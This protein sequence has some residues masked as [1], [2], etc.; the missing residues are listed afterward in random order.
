[1]M[2]F[3]CVIFSGELLKPTV[4][5]PVGL[6]SLYLA[7]VIVCWCV[8]IGLALV[9]LSWGSILVVFAASVTSLVLFRK[10][11]LVSSF[12]GTIWPQLACLL[13]A[14]SLPHSSASLFI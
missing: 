8:F 4:N 7:P 9:V 13:P 1:M 14:S 2:I 10:T 6:T 12:I 3:V 11:T 5:S